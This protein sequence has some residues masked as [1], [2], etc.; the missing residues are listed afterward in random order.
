M[1]LNLANL[2]KNKKYLVAVSGGPDSMYLL[3]FMSKYTNV[4]AAHV[5]YNKRDSAKRDQKIVEDYCKKNNIKLFVNSVNLDVNGNFQEKAR[6]QRYEWFV[7]L[8][9]KHKCKGIV[10]GQHKDD[11]IET[12]LMQI[13]RNSHL[14]YFG[15]A[16][17][18][19]IG[20]KD[21][22]RPMLDIYKSDVIKTLKKEKV[23]FGVDE[24]NQM[25]IYKRNVIRKNI[26]KMS[27][28]EKDEIVSEIT[29]A[30]NMNQV[31]QKRVNKFYKQ[32]VL[33]G[34]IKNILFTE[35]E[36][37]FIFLVL[38]KYLKEEGYIIKRINKKIINEMESF[39]L[40]TL[41]EKAKMD[42]A[43]NWVFVKDGDISYIKE[44]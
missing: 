41:K 19:K 20:G 12:Y 28:K 34:K 44:E 21:F 5:N 16:P 42:M 15:I 10:I 9:K 39:I 30:N 38:Y 27:V 1:Y 4:I 13:E 17:K 11:V 37:E 24:T 7:E 35:L 29:L 43:G 2:D 6:E 23:K 3:H 25:D 40:K 26:E 32:Y 14:E 31:R 22:I 33:S 36:D 18:T 8:A